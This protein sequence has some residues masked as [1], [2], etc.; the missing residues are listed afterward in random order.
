MARLPRK[1]LADSSFPKTAARGVTRHPRATAANT[2]AAQARAAHNSRA[3]AQASA[4][5][6]PRRVSEQPAPLRAEDDEDAEDAQNGM[7]GIGGGDANA[8]TMAHAGSLSQIRGII[9]K[10][11]NL[12]DRIQ[13]ARSRLPGPSESMMGGSG[14][15]RASPRS[16]P[17]G[18]PHGFVPVTANGAIGVRSGMTRSRASGSGSVASATSGD[19]VPSSSHVSAAALHGAA[20]ATSTPVGLR[21]TS[22]GQHTHSRSTCASDS[23]P[24]SRTSRA[25][26]SGR[27]SVTSTS[28]AGGNDSAA[29]ATTNNAIATKS[30]TLAS[31]SSSSRLHQMSVNGSATTTTTTGTSN[32]VAAAAAA[33]KELIRRPRS[34]VSTNSSSTTGT[35]GMSNIDE[36]DADGYSDEVR[37]PVAQRSINVSVYD[38]SSSS[39]SA[40]SSGIHSP[41]HIPTT[42]SPSNVG[43]LSSIYKN[44]SLKKP[45]TPISASSPSSSAA[46]AATRETGIPTP[47]SLS[48]SAHHHHSSKIASPAG[49]HY[50]SSTSPAS[51]LRRT[52]GTGTQ[53]R[54]I[55]ALD[56]QGGS[57]GH[58]YGHGSG[59]GAGSP[60]GAY[61][62]ALRTATQQQDRKR[63]NTHPNF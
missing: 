19:S 54:I 12:E 38:P 7:G 29:A 16:P 42:P 17:N 43:G 27:S 60:L 9:G 5:A 37:T 24:S 11:R 44:L 3:A 13:N 36:A 63:A 58:G 41:S 55:S 23:R 10:M 56:G 50:S 59:S 14:S 35:T 51:T 22:V 1:S 57:P 62:A 30:H 6:A 18:L 4:N 33:K 2:R 8:H 25:S 40:T 46:A 20:I 52:N 48:S 26:L 61:G 28:Y 31:S 45:L 47:P 34:S 15:M 32:S 21:R 49:S 39:A 53:R